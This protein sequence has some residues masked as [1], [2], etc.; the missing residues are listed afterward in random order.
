M[1]HLELDKTEGGYR[2]HR[3]DGTVE[4]DVYVSYHCAAS[5]VRWLNLTTPVAAPAAQPRK[6]RALLLRRSR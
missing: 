6:R 1:A 4:T 3:A 2:V 5:R